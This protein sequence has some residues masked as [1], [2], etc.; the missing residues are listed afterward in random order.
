MMKD[1]T[2]DQVLQTAEMCVRLHL[3]AIF[4]FIVGFPSESHESVR[5]TV[6][7]IKRLRAMNPDFETPWFYFKPYPGS[8][9]T[10]ELVRQGYTLPVTL[11]E[12]AA[13]DFIGSSGPWVSD[14]KHRWF[15]RF[16]FYNRFAGGAETWRR[17]PLQ[18]PARW[19]CRRDF[20]GLPLERA[21]VER[22]RPTT[23][24]S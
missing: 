2:V 13:F 9:I 20:Y 15:E 12:W 19:R 4:P 17:W 22:L 8:R 21:I 5:A 10:D 3:G 16:K 18:R 24:L 7:L 14:E 6:A 23:P 11:E 1:V